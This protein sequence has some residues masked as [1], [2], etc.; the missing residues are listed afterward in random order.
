MIAAAVAVDARIVVAAMVAAIESAEIDCAPYF[1]FAP[2]A[3]VTIAS[4]AVCAT[5]AT[6]AACDSAA[7]AAGFASVYSAECETAAMAEACDFA[8]VAADSES[9]CFAVYAIA[10][11]AV[12]GE[13]AACVADALD[14]SLDDAPAACAAASSNRRTALAAVYSPAPT[15]LLVS[16]SASKP[17]SAR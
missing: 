15:M 6:V 17:T 4:V 7:T 14:E 5:E 8:A 12:A 13:T 3:P 16:Q 1:D 11:C 9:V 10:E 2:V